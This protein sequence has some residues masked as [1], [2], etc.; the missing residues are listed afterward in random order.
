MIHYTYWFFKGQSGVQGT[1]FK[2]K[3][4]LNNPHCLFFLNTFKADVRQQYP[5]VLKEATNFLFSAKWSFV[6]SVQV[7]PNVYILVGIS[8]LL[9]SSLFFFN[10]LLKKS[11]NVMKGVN[12]NILKTDLKI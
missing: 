5:T 9:H 11:L 6:C 3:N 12:E 10:N 2:T 8:H 1:S 4:L 7:L